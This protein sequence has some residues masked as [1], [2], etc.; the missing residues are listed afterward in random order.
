[1]IILN[2]IISHNIQQNGDYLMII[3]PRSDF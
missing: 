3:Q 1:M 2:H